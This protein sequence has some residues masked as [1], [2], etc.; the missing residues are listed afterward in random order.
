[1]RSSTVTTLIEYEAMIRA[2]GPGYHPD[3]PAEQYTDLPEGITPER[4]RAIED[5]ANHVLANIFAFANEIVRDELAKKKRYV[6]YFSPQAW[7]N[8]NAIEVDPEGEQEWDCTREFW[9]MD[10][11]YR[12]DLLDAIKADGQVLDDEDWLK[13]D[14]DAPEWVR[15][16]QGPFSIWVREAPAQ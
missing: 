10:G 12:K 1:M 13:G 11:D 4:I 7:V 6:A 16:F 2:I 9:S 5:E 3:T 15:E 14:T 8:D